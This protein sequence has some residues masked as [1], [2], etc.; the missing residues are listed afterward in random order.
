MLS[1]TAEM[2]Q[3]FE[4]GTKYTD[5]A[6]SVAVQ[7]QIGKGCWTAFPYKVV[8]KPKRSMQ[9]VFAIVAVLYNARFFSRHCRDV[10]I[11]PISDNQTKMHKRTIETFKV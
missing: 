1:F 2:L 6:S 10:P 4:D 7:V 3:G 9:I 11:L 8:V 5:V